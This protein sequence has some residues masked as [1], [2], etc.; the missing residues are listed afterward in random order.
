MFQ[1]KEI[2][3]GKNL[4]QERAWFV[5]GTKTSNGLSSIDSEFAEQIGQIIQGI[6]EHDKDF[7]LYYESL[8]QQKW[9]SRA[10]LGEKIIN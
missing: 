8:Y 9:R 10:L 1:K 7:G 5:Q 2:I 4:T 3:C 6:K